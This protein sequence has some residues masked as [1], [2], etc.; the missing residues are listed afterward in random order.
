MLNYSL[1]L[2][3]YKNLFNHFVNLESNNKLPSK[4][5]LSGQEGIGKSTFALHFINYLLSKNEVTKYNLEENKINHESI[6]FNLLNNISHPNFNY[7]SKKDV[8]KNIEID[9][10]RNM[11][12]SLNKSSFNNNKKNNIN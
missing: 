6:S 10:I 7:I 8:K 2:I 5:L 11:I 12:N 1:K 4:I 3:G 9:Q